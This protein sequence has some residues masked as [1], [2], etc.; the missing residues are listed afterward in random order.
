MIQDVLRNLV[1]L[2]YPKNICPWDQQEEYLKTIEYKKLKAI[3]DYYDSDENLKIRNNIKKE[4]EGD[5]ILKD[6]EDFSRFDCNDRCFTFFLSIIEGGELL[7]ISLHISILLPYYSIRK[8]WHHHE[9]WFTKERME[10]LEREN[11][12]S[13]KIEDLILDVESI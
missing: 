3:I 5:L 8:G 12:D 4:F 1:Y 11:L 7:S 9:P 6:F 10:E 13:R 2:F